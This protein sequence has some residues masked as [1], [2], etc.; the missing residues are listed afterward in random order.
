M[1]FKTG[2]ESTLWRLRKHDEQEECKGEV[3]TCASE[4]I[5]PHHD[6]DCYDIT[7]NLALTTA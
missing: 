4:L 5:E 1:L 2:V 3:M 7:S 6:I